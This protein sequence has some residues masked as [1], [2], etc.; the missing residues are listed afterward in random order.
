MISLICPV[1]GER[2]K[3]EENAYICPKRHSFDI[4][5]SGYVNLLPSSGSGRHGD[6]KL[7]VRARTQF[8]NKGYYR[9]LALRLAEIAAT[10]RPGL[11]V[12]AG[13]GEGY[14][15]DIVSLASE[16][17]ETVGLDISKAAVAAAAKRCRRGVFAVASTV[18]MPLED[19]CADV[20][21]NVFS[22]FFPAEFARVLKPGGLLLRVIPLE[23]HL[24][25]LRQLV[26]ESP[27]DNTVPELEAPGLELLGTE[28]LKYTICIDGSDDISSLFM[29]TPYYYKTSAADQARL[30]E[31]QALTTR[32]EFG[33]V[34]YRAMP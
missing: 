14:Y 17:A 25:E 1:C 11:I 16:G 22:P 12:D 2:L 20:I 31:A 27:Y 33:I 5:K 34:S 26:Y 32:V 24:H 21:L 8:L 6:D 9:P 30:A 7:M 3:R 19:S 10:E 28:E 15:T 4:A 29:M 23:L 13:C 18:S